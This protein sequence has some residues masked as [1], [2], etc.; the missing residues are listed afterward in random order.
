MFG[1]GCGKLLDRMAFKPGM[2]I[3]LSR[4]QETDT[5]HERRGSASLQ[6]KN[7][8]EDRLYRIEGA[9]D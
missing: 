9:P 4:G 8:G 3:A 1:P 2:A 6:L 5:E 7:D